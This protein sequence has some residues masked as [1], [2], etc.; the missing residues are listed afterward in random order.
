MQCSERHQQQG[1]EQRA[2]G[3]LEEE[4]A[5]E[6]TAMGKL[7]VWKPQEENERRRMEPGLVKNNSMV[8]IM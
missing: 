3:S 6:T 7:K 8:Q 2:S 4:S 1:E 5:W